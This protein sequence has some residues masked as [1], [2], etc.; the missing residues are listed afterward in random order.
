MT[1]RGSFRARTFGVVATSGAVHLVVFASL[2]LIPSPSEVLARREMEFEVVEPPKAEPPPPPPLPPPEPEK[3]KE[4]QQRAAPKAEPEPTPE[5]PEKPAEAPQEE[6]ADF[7]GTTLTAEGGG[8]WS[9]EV[10][11]G[12]A[13]KGPVGKIGRAQPGPVQ[14]AA[15]AVT[16]GPRVVAVGSLS[17]KPKPPT[18]LDTL[19]EQNYPQRARMQGVE[20]RVVIKLRILP[21]GR[22]GE[23]DVVEEFPK[24]FEFAAACRKTLHEAPPFVPGLDQGGAAVATDIKFNCDFVVDD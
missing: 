13:L 20:G 10:G 9:T 6:V 3:P 22:V 21:N 5:E 15:K 4:P 8:G 18:G 11:S 7:T 12:G 2:G 23:M 19:L 14:Q 16:A 1:V 17:R 24:S